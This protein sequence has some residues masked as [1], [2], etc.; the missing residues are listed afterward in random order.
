MMMTI[1]TSA[2]VR[3]CAYALFFFVCLDISTVLGQQQVL[4]CKACMLE[5]NGSRAV[6]DVKP[7]SV[8]GVSALNIY[9]RRGSPTLTVG[10]VDGLDRPIFVF[11]WGSGSVNMAE[12]I[13]WKSQRLA[14]FIT[15]RHAQVMVDYSNYTAAFR[16]DPW[17][18][19]YNIREY[20]G[21]NVSVTFCFSD[22]IVIRRGLQF[23]RIWGLVCGAILQNT[24]WLFDQL[25]LYGLVTEQLREKKYWSS[26]VLL[27]EKL[28]GIEYYEDVVPLPTSMKGVKRKYFLFTGDPV[29][30]TGDP[31]MF[32]YN[33]L[34]RLHTLESQGLVDDAQQL[35]FDVT[36]LVVGL[37]NHYYIAKG[38]GIAHWLSIIT[39]ARSQLKGQYVSALSI[40][41]IYNN[42]TIG[43]IVS[44]IVDTMTQLMRKRK[45]EREHDPG[46]DFGLQFTEQDIIYSDDDLRCVF[47][48]FYS[49]YLEKDEP[50]N[51]DKNPA[52]FIG[53]IID[54]VDIWK[55]PVQK[56]FNEQRHDDSVRVLPID[57]AYWRLCRDLPRF[58]FIELKQ[59]YGLARCYED[60]GASEENAVLWAESKIRRKYSEMY[61]FQPQGLFT[62]HP[63]LKA[64]I[65]LCA[66]AITVLGMKDMPLDKAISVVSNSMRF[67]SFVRGADL[68]SS[69]LEG[70]EVVFTTLKTIY[71]TGSFDCLVDCSKEMTETNKEVSII[72]TELENMDMLNLEYPTAWLQARVSRLTE[73]QHKYQAWKVR[74]PHKRVELDALISN[75]KL[76]A[77][78]ANNKFQSLSTRPKPFC[79]LL[80]GSSSIGKTTL[81]NM[82]L[83]QYVAD[84]PMNPD[85]SVRNGGPGLDYN[86]HAYATLGNT[87]DEYDTEISNSQWGLIF[88]DVAVVGPKT[89]NGSHIATLINKLIKIINI[90]PA[91]TQQASLD[92]KGKIFHNQSLIGITT[93]TPTMFVEQVAA[94]SAAIFRRIDVFVE[95]TVK[96]EFVRDG[97]TQLDSEKVSYFSPYQD[98]KGQVV[99]A[100]HFHMYKYTVNGDR[101]TRATI[102]KTGST[103]EFLRKMSDLWYAHAKS[104][105]RTQKNC[106]TGAYTICRKCHMVGADVDGFCRY[107]GC[108]N[109]G[110]PSGVASLFNLGMKLLVEYRLEWVPR[111]LT[112][113]AALSSVCLEEMIKRTGFGAG[114]PVFEYVAYVALFGSD[115]WL[116]RILP[117]CLHY[118]WTTMPLQEAI[119]CHLVY[120]LLADGLERKYR[121]VLLASMAGLIREYY[122]VLLLAFYVVI[123]SDV[124]VVTYQWL[125]DNKLFVEQVAVT[126]YVAYVLIEKRVLAALGNSEI[127]HRVRLPICSAVEDTVAWTWERC[128]SYYMRWFSTHRK[129]VIFFS[130]VLTAVVV[131]KGARV[132]GNLQTFKPQGFGNEP[133]KGKNVWASVPVQTPIHSPGTH[134]R[135]FA[136]KIV[137]NTVEIVFKHEGA[138]QSIKALAIAGSSFIMTKHE[139][140]V[141][142]SKGGCKIS[143]RQ[144]DRVNVDDFA[145]DFEIVQYRAPRSASQ[146]FVDEQNFNFHPDKDLC[147][148]TVNTTPFPSLVSYFPTA[149][150]ATINNARSVGV[151]GNRQQV[152]K[153]PMLTYVTNI[154]IRGQCNQNAY[155]GHAFDS[156]DQRIDCAVG[157]CG[158]VLFNAVRGCNAIYGIHNSGNEANGICAFIPIVRADVEY[159]LRNVPIMDVQDMLGQVYPSDAGQLV[160]QQEKQAFHRKNAFGFCEPID[161]SPCRLW[162]TLGNAC[163]IELKSKFTES[164][165]VDWWMQAKVRVGTEFRAMMD[166]PMCVPR[167]PARWRWLP[168]YRFAEI[169]TQAKEYLPPTIVQGLANKYLDRLLANDEFVARL[170]GVVPL[171]LDE[172]VNGIS[173]ARYVRSL[174]M[175][176]SAG[177]PYNKPKREICDFDGAKYH[178]PHVVTERF[179]RMVDRL[180]QGRMAGIIFSASVK[181][182]PVSIKK[183]TSQIQERAPGDVSKEELNAAID[184]GFGKIRVFQAISLEGCLI[185]RTFF[186]MLVSL[187]QEFRYVSCIAV[188][189]NCF[190][191]EWDELYRYMTPDWGLG[192]HNF[193]CGDFSNY[194]QRI[195]TEFLK[196]AWHV[197]RELWMH[198]DYFFQLDPEE[199]MG[200]IRLLDVLAI[201]MS[202]PLSW[203]WGDLVHLQGGNASGHPLTVI[204][205]GIVNYMYML[206]AFSQIYPERDFNEMVR[207]MTYGDDNILTVHPSCPNFNQIEITRVLAEIGVIYTSSDKKVVSAPY[208]EK[209]VFLKRTWVER[210]HD[211]D[212]TLY[213][214]YACP[215]DW[216]SFSKTLSV[217]KK[218]GPDGDVRMISVLLSLSLEMMQYGPTTYN[219]FL[220]V[221]EQF[222]TEFKLKGTF[223]T[224]AKRGWM[225]MDAFLRSRSLREDV[226]PSLSPNFSDSETD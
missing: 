199:R 135:P 90:A 163:Q 104:E 79:F 139:A 25:T 5:D 89:N 192:G 182:E 176:S 53:H 74:N 48:A 70:L 92:R 108:R 35:A 15:G 76:V 214:Y 226:L 158:N 1:N 60:S 189:L 28:Y 43:P 10:T 127:I 167:L 224:C 169:V 193:I 78:V 14:D 36:L 208:E 59:V 195:A 38:E 183:I 116:V 8:L 16:F 117:L 75:C 198:T 61:S 32:A 111:Y 207:F 26:Y 180:R 148:I 209:L 123:R 51:R 162:M 95:I 190:S 22:S 154:P 170:R 98:Q 7:L 33:M 178:L 220:E 101:A 71:S 17:Y 143:L 197:L 40:N 4:Q 80:G 23:T 200:F 173:G 2:R 83:S 131:L 94:H 146:L 49:L 132:L 196:Q 188:G 151:N 134:P 191:Q 201:E 194:D 93:N 161:G 181:D 103:H 41:D 165:F 29:F 118:L 150:Q 67:H 109:P 221:A 19:E 50:S 46:D 125:C 85:V 205:N 156:E 202:N 121:T 110:V 137:M 62:S 222:L 44:H 54:M 124:L 140:M 87:T 55:L 159:F 210:R 186:L 58:S 113:C 185:I 91:S 204:I 47:D 141:L 13:D 130:A 184:G 114:F 225:S 187:L 27:L 24:G 64:L 216:S 133:V 212:G 82:I 219:S 157:F 105:A 206:Y 217:E 11:D 120:N 106:G 68:A 63:A 18:D 52:C 122:N 107:R 6:R 218:L 57:K 129:Y 99:D 128:A 153:Y 42:V 45:E 174:N 3:A 66:V 152:L 119:V 77:D 144:P 138:D 168:Q 20:Y 31:E 37:Y 9:Y 21:F 100:W 164:R 203:F 223:T 115:V 86:A 34:I 97:S 147:V 65:S 96:D 72:M 215:L 171:T 69:I 155:L 73:I 112:T 88:D 81:L 213:T 56:R 149:V 179:A 177:Y 30:I 175:N 166:S 84:A 136:S 39:F 211:L 142:Y 102:F 172:A 145:D 12:A 160:Y 126:M